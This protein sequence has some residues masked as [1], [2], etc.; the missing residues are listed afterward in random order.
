MLRATFASLWAWLA[1]LFGDPLAVLAFVLA[2]GAGGAA[3]F[4]LLAKSAL[5]GLIFALVG[6][7]I[8][9]GLMSL[10]PRVGGA[11]SLGGNVGGAAVLAALF[12]S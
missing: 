11:L 5:L 1:R 12:L 4:L 3:T 9:F 8:V 2:V 7:P 6:I 10:V